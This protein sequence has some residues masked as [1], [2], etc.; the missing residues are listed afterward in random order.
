MMINQAEVRR[1][2]LETAA[3]SKFRF[4]GGNKVARFT[5]ISDSFFEHINAVAM[6]AITER[7]NQHGS[8]GQTLT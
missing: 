5:R 4:E 2:A 1:Y 3:N 7:I 6:R 8:K